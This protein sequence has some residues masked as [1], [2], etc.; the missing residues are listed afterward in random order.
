MPR[1]DGRHDFDDVFERRVGGF[2]RLGVLDD[3]RNLRPHLDVRGIESGFRLM[4]HHV[5][6]HLDETFELGHVDIRIG[7]QPFKHR[8]FAQGR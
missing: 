5:F 3:G 1:E 6:L 7:R 2:V 4:R 8:D